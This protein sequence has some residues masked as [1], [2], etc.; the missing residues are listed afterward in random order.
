MHSNNKLELLFS[1]RMGEQDLIANSR[2]V[3]IIC[4]AFCMFIQNSILPLNFSL[5][6]SALYRPVSTDNFTYTCL[7]AQT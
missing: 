6:S 4:L 5:V 3:T 1:N 2:N 7:M